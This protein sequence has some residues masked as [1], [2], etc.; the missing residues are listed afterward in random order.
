MLE[1]MGKRPRDPPGGRFFVSLVRG[2]TQ[3]HEAERATM[4]TMN[5][6]IGSSP[7]ARA[8]QAV[9][10]QLL[11]MTTE[12]LSLQERVRS[13]EFEALK[14]SVKLTGEI[15]HWLK[16]ALETEQRCEDR[17]KEQLGIVND[18]A[19]DFERARFEIGCRLDRLRNRV[20]PARIPE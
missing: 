3:A 1:E 11:G 5:P 4:T 13:G 9:E 8:I 10:A 20:C 14:D 19:I 16:M 17:R 6:E 18:Y 7:L 12:L 15:R 2:P